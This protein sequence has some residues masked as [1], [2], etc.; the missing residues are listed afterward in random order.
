MRN[1]QLQRTPP[2]CYSCNEKLLKMATGIPTMCVPGIA[3]NGLAHLG[4]CPGRPTEP[5]SLLARAGVD[6]QAHQPA[7]INERLANVA[8]RKFEAVIVRRG[9]CTAHRDSIAE[10]HL[11][12]D[13]EPTT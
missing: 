4:R 6:P 3:P 10:P 8:C 1:R 2:S 11:A 12:C 7:H 9:V 13:L 5:M